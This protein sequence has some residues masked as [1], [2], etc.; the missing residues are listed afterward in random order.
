M[1]IYPA[2][3]LTD[4][5]TTEAYYAGFYAE[6]MIYASVKTADGWA[7]RVLDA[8]EY[9]LVDEDNADAT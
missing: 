1:L 5:E 2:L 6:G 9:T 8:G 7:E 4:D 3:R